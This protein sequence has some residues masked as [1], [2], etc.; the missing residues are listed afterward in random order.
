[1]NASLYRLIFSKVLG[2][3]VPVSEIKTAGRRKTARTRRGASRPARLSLLSSALCMAFGLAGQSFAQIVPAGGATTTHHSASGVSIVNIAA[4]DAHGLSHNVFQQFNTVAPG[5]VFNNST[6]DGR[7]KIAGQISR[8]PNLGAAL[9]STIL[10][11]VTGAGP[12]SLRGALEVFGGKANLIIA[13][14]NGISVNGLTTLNTNSLTLSTGVPTARDGRVTLG[15]DQGKITVGGGGVNTDGLSTFDLV[16]K[17]IQIDGAIGDGTGAMTDIKAVAGSGA[18]DTATRGLAGRRVPRAAGVSHTGYAIDGSAAG[19]MHGKAIALIST[20]AGLGVRQPGMLVSPGDI[21]VDAKGNIEVG[22]AKARQVGL[23]SRADVK[24]GRVQTEGKLSATAGGSLAMDALVIGNGAALTAE[25]G[26][27]RLGPDGHKDV[28]SS[29]LTGELD[30]S[31][32]QGSFILSRGFKTDVLKVRAK[33]WV[34]RNAVAEVTGKDGVSNSVDI[35][36][37]GRIVLTGSLHGTDDAGNPIADS[38]VKVIDGRPVVLRASTGD[39]LHGHSVGSSVGVRALKGDILL[40]GGTLENQNSVVAALAGKTTVELTGGLDNQGLIQGKAALSVSAQNIKN[41]FELSSLG[42]ADVTARGK[43]ENHGEISTLTEAGAAVA[44][45]RDHLLTLR[46]GSAL[47]N[48]G[49]IASAGKIVIEGVDGQ[50]GPTKRAA[51]VN[52]SAGRIDSAA[53]SISAERFNN[54][55]GVTVRKSGTEIDVAGAFRSTGRFM[56]LGKTGDAPGLALRAGSLYVNGLLKSAQDMKLAIA[57]DTEFGSGARS[58]PRR[59]T[60]PPRT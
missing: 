10:S 42:K 59:W 9:A 12:S 46:A 41:T 3:Y 22:S 53:L 11:E 24:A 54:Q 37:S 31:V 60:S 48:S 39:T 18:F 56:A 30:I 43:L 28:G 23:H 29:E 58:R 13:N 5:V 45:A 40:K 52:E 47:V 20:D 51:I 4:P 16:A 1:M 38:L 6:A 33:N 44:S 17:M 35:D 25:S 15:V 14:P 55:G 36:V 19:A 57:N 49:F 7:S 26:D 2:M 32:R 34:L 21:T 27:L 8:N 50:G